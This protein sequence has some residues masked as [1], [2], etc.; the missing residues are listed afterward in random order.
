MNNI[1]KR[2]K[3]FFFKIDQH[4]PYIP[5]F[6]DAWN[7]L[8]IMLVSFLICVIYSFT[9]VSKASEFYTKFW[10]NIKIFAP[11]VIT[12]LL[13]LIFNANRIKSMKPA[14]AILLILFLNFICVYL[15]YAALTR[16]F[17]TFFTEWDATVAKFCVSLGILFFFLIYFDWREKNLHPSH[18]KAKLSFLQS[19]MRPHFLFNTLNSI[20][21][22]IK[23][24]PEKAKKM[25]LNLSELLRASLREEDE[26]FFHTLSQEIH[27]CEKY[28]EIEKM[29]LGERLEVIW[30]VQENISEVKI[31]RLV[32]QP[33]IENS[34]LHGIQ[35]LENGGKVE[36]TIRKNLLNHLTIEIKNPKPNIPKSE[37][38][39]EDHNN[40]SMSNLSQ[41]LKICYEGDITFKTNDSNDSFYV[42]IEIP[43]DLKVQDK[44]F[45]F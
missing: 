14:N 7:I 6:S 21:S 36:I 25:L 2:I 23:R 37:L 42:F 24:D 29:R 4:V 33:L 28:L 16:S 27:L 19:K 35:K 8:K 11:Y 39:K 3:H 38:E 20:V 41:R 17:E 12:Q 10:L 26:K 22:L 5:D 44:P 40:I 30:E 43:T 9:E 18:I 13:L 31:P 32:I 45:S 34:I 15:V 1:Q